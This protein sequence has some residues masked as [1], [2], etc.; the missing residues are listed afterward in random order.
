MVV[1]GLEACAEGDTCFGEG[2]KR[3]GTVENGS[4]EGIYVG[5]GLAPYVGSRRSGDVEGLWGWGTWV[6]I[7]CGPICCSVSDSHCDLLSDKW[8]VLL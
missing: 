8:K 1:E 5:V 2:G 4:C 6:G 3:H 7:A